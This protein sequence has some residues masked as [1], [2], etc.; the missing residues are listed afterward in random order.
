MAAAYD[1]INNEIQVITIHP[2]T[3]QE[4]SNKL[5]RKRWIKNEKN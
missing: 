4:I 2:T 5:S 1:I 3:N